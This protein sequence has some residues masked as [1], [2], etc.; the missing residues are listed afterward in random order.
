MSTAY[1]NLVV[2]EDALFSGASAGRDIDKRAWLIGVAHPR[3]PRIQARLTRDFTVA[4]TLEAELDRALLR[5]AKSN[6]FAAEHHRLDLIGR[7]ER[8][9]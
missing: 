5:V 8:C 7:C 2:F 4:D 6:G 9:R 1:R 3:V